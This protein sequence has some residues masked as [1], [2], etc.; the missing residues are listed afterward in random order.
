MRFRFASPA[1]V[2]ALAAMNEQLIRD[3][4]HHN[5]MTLPELERRM[6]DFLQRGYSAVLFENP[7]A[8]TAGY[9]LYRVEPEYA[10]L[11]QFF[12]AHEHRRRGIGRAAFTWLRENP[13][14]NRPRIRLEV[15]VGNQRGIRFWRSI[16]FQDYCLIME[17]EQSDLQA[18]PSTPA[19]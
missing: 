19:A 2:P 11:R 17:A 1:D 4:G 3:E 6:A 12:V 8:A 16:G 7:G 15:L 14:R 5:Q 10:Y 18:A 9:A 13:W